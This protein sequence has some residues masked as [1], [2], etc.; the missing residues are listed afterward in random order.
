M[1]R[2]RKAVF[3]TISAFKVLKKASIAVLKL[4]YL[5]IKQFI[6]PD[7]DCSNLHFAAPLNKNL[8]S[9]QEYLLK[10]IPQ[11]NTILIPINE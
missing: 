7:I 4:Q 3:Q 2:V 8:H 11:W 9:P 6:L 1:A 10:N 5:P